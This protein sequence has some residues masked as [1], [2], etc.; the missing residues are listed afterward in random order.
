MQPERRPASSPRRFAVVGSGLA[1]LLTAHGLLKAGH[2]VNLFSDRTPEQWF[3][4]SSPTGSAL[5]FT[6]SLEYERDLELHHWESVAPRAWGFHATRCFRP[7]GQPVCSVG[8]FGKGEHFQ[9]VDLRLQS[10]RWMRDFEQRGG[11]LILENVG[12]DRLD[13]V[14]AAHDLT[15]IATGK[16]ALSR[17]FERDP[18]RS[19]FD[20]PQRHQAMLIVTG[21]PQQVDG[22][23][24]LPIKL[25]LLEGAGEA[26]WIPYYH[27][28]AGPSWNLVFEAAPGG[29]LDRF[30]HAASGA[31]VLEIAWRLIRE[32]FPWDSIWAGA[33]ELADER[34]WL[35]GRLT[36]EVRRPVARLRAGSVVTGVGDALVLLDPITGSGAASGS[37]MAQNLVESVLAHGDRPFDEAWMSAT[38]ERYWTRHGG[39]I[40]S[41]HNFVLRPKSLADLLT[42]RARGRE[43][44]L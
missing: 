19:P 33:M 35:V 5:R 32:A 8:W 1:G 24:F 36:P 39:R 11:R 38:F 37:R 20:R 30:Q 3:H 10:H 6:E 34:A 18:S 16:G 7:G 13:D 9:A 21:L 26:A 23:P 44:E 29:P 4:E 12:V 2:A 17:I 28:D 22:V 25:S 27:R 15:V 43:P 41:F 14:A 40:N 42:A 31:E